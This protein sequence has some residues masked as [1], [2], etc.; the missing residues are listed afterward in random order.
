[1]PIDWYLW[2]ES[3]FLIEENWRWRKRRRKKRCFFVFDEFYCIHFK[4][5][6]VVSTM[7]LYINILVL[8]YYFN[9]LFFCFVCVSLFGLWK[10]NSKENRTIFFGK[11]FK[12]LL[13]SRKISII[14]KIKIHKLRQTLISSLFTCVFFFCF[15]FSA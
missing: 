2:T 5:E 8:N 6:V 3:T 11:K 15:F 13:V 1:M 14:L 7:S 12:I 4:F 10:L 9:V